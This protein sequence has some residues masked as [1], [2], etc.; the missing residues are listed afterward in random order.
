MNDESGEQIDERVRRL[1]GD[2]TPKLQAAALPWRQGSDGVEIL[3]I[4]SKDTGRWVLP[5]GNIDKGE[6]PWRAAEREAEEEAGIRGSIS[7]QETGRYLYA[8]VQFIG[9]AVPVEVAVYPLE[10]AEMADDWQEADSRSRSWVS[11]E[12][13][14]SMVDEPDLADLIASFGVVLGE[15]RKS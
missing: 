14:T 13:A 9:K 7:H 15:Q 12:E 3:L 11:A 4:T 6:K 2:A 8:K 1:F 10:V 5:K